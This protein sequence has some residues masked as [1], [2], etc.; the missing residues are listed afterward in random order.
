MERLEPPRLASSASEPIGPSAIWAKV[1]PLLQRLQPEAARAHG[2]VPLLVERL[3]GHGEAVPHEF[4]QEERA[5]KMANAI[6]PAVLA[7]ARS[8]YDGRM[9]VLKGPEV[10]VLYPGRARMLVDLDLL[11]DDAPAA[12]EALL[13]AGFESADRLKS[14][15]EAFYHM[16][17]VELPGVPLPIELHKSFRWP[18]GLH[19]AP[20]EDLFA[21]AVPSSVGVPGL[22]APSKPHHA[23]LLAAHA[24]AERPL[25]RLRD[26]FDIAAMAD[27][28]AKD[29]LKEIAT[30][31]GWQRIWR[32]DQRAIDWLLDDGPKPLAVGLWARHLQDV[33]EASA[34]DRA[35]AYW[36]SPFWATRAVTAMHV[37]GF[38]AK[39]A[40]LTRGVHDP[41]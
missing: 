34:L 10:S 35:L 9:M 3:R 24:W 28:I 40:A 8:A 22:L 23:V 14:V 18:N 41:D 19:P 33:R 39:K 29:E 20:N 12:R 11:V 4:L 6:A 38:L 7:R 30:Q 15:S 26:L 32:T 16:N 31:W 21:A 37:V 36:L 5:A 13:R 25:E 1:D 17:P 27:G 2:V